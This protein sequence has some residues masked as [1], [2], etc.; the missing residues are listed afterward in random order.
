MLCGRDGSCF[1]AL[2]PKCSLSLE[3]D[4]VMPPRVLDGFPKSTCLTVVQAEEVC[5][6]SVSAGC[7][8]DN[9]SC[10]TA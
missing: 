10:T 5:S 2:L 4:A 6:A 9:T 7:N 1:I 3:L 8:A